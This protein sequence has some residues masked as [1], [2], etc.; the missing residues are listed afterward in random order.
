[1][2]YLPVWIV[3]G[4]NDRKPNPALS[5]RIAKS[6]SS[7]GGTVRYTLLKNTGHNTL[8]PML[9]NPALFDYLSR[10]NKLNPVRHGNYL[11]IDSVYDGYRWYLDCKIIKDENKYLI[12]VSRPGS[13]SV[14]VNDHG[15]WSGLSP[16]PIDVTK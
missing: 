7:T 10:V 16:S 8:V 2:K 9:V 5:Q 3:Q 4:A 12:R 1:M 6:I 15:I 13:Y 11:K 14:Q